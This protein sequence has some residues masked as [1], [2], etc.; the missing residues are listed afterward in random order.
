MND[1]EKQL[2]IQGL[3]LDLG[4]AC[5]EFILLAPIRTLLDALARAVLNDARAVV[6]KTVRANDII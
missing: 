6:A 3:S 4:V 5:D 2:T 1:S